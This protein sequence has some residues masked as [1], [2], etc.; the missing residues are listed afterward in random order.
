MQF[1]LN[2]SAEQSKVK[3]PHPH[4]IEYT[5]VEDGNPVQTF[6][7]LQTIKGGGMRH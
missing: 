7:L 1:R 2:T 5:E 4:R 6:A 3:S